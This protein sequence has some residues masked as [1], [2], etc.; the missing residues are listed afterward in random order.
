MIL[1]ICSNENGFIPDQLETEPRMKILLG[2]LISKLLKYLLKRGLAHRILTY[3]VSTLDALIEAEKGP[4]G[5][6]PSRNSKLVIVIVV[7]EDLNSSEC[8]TQSVNDSEAVILDVEPSE[9]VQRVDLTSVLEFA[10]E[11]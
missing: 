1:L 8:L 11:V 3:I 7:L 9:E 10:E 2:L 6:I 4:Y 5:F